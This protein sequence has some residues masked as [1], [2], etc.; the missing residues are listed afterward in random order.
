M[1]SNKHNVKGNSAEHESTDPRVGTN[2]DQPELSVGFLPFH[3]L[4]RDVI[5][6][7][8]Q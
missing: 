6:E 3:Y 7:N 2:E 4:T 1:T 5:A 8:A